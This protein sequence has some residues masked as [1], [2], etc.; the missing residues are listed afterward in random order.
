MLLDAYPNPRAGGVGVIP[1]DPDRIQA[2]A[3]GV[4]WDAPAAVVPSTCLPPAPRTERDRWWITITERWIREAQAW[5]QRSEYWR[6]RSG[7]WR[8]CFWL[9]LALLALTWA[10]VVW[11]GVREAVK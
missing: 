2:H 3:L 8:D 7:Q 6:R 10:W 5:Y 11:L 9:T 1:Q 4:A